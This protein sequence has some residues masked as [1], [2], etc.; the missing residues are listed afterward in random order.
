MSALLM[1]LVTGTAL[2]LITACRLAE[3]SPGG[4]V[5]GA[6]EAIRADIAS[7]GLSREGKWRRQVP[8]PDWDVAF[9]EGAVYGWE[10]DT[11]HGPIRVEL[12]PESAPR[13]VLS[14]IYLTELGFYDGLVFHRVI[15]GFMAQGGCPDGDGRGSPGYRYAGEFS[16]A[17]RHEG[18]GVLS[19]A[20]A[21]PGTDGSQFFITFKSTPHL[22]GHHTV[23]GRVV[24]GD[25]TLVRMEDLGSS[26]GGAT[27]EPIT[28]RKARIIT[29]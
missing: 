29:G 25:E 19:M 16:G 11:S 17:A 27:R 2:A 7:K 18:R 14:T 4:A 22:D 3:P 26:P 8:A 10:L 15:P 12:L 1:L 13:H 28:I 20:N 24:S 6:L 9:P 5:D 23:F 21:G